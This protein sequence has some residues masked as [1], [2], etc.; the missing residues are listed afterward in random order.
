VPENADQNTVVEDLGRLSE[1]WRKDFIEKFL[2]LRKV[3]SEW[4]DLSGEHVLTVRLV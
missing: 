1:E 2:N 4:S 3:R